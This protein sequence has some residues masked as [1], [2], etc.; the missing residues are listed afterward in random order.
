MTLRGN[1]SAQALSLTVLYAV[2]LFRLFC[3]VPRFETAREVARNAA[4]A[5]N[6][7]AAA[8]GA[9]RVNHAFVSA[10]A[11]GIDGMVD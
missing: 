9:T 11:A 4:Y 6:V 2:A 5:R 8:N 7:F 10:T 1:I 3:G